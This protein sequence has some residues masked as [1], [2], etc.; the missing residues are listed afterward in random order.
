MA[1]GARWNTDLP[2]PFEELWEDYERSLKR[3][4]RSP[5]TVQ[6]NRSGFERL[7]LYV[8]SEHGLTC[9]EDIVRDHVHKWVEYM[10][11]GLVDADRPPV[12]L[13]VGG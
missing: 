2:A 8:V 1:T 10:I 7:I 13:V 9:V 3:L 12:L 11:D 4:K 5:N 6:M